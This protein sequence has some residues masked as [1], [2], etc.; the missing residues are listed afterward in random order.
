MGGFVGVSE[1]VGGAKT[2]AVAE[3]V[4]VADNVPP[5]IET[6]ILGATGFNFC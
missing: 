6:G 3:I 5:V 1:A 4:D 2:T